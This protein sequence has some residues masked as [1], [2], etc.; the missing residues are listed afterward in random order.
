MGESAENTSAM[1][2]E[3]SE[4]SPT[5]SVKSRYKLSVSHLYNPS[6]SGSENHLYAPYDSYSDNFLISVATTDEV[7]AV[8]HHMQH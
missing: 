2:N 6:P 8:L 3:S 5:N 4:Q 1:V 7:L